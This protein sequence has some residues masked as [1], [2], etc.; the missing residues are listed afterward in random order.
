MKTVQLV[1]VGLAWLACSLANGYTIVSNDN[2]V[3]GVQPSKFQLTI[4]QDAATQESTGIWFDYDGSELTAE[5][6]SVDEGS[7]WYVVHAGDRFT[8]E[9]IA[10]GDFTPLVT[11][12][13][14]LQPSAVVGSEDFYLGVVTGTWNE[15]LNPR[16]V[17]GW[18]HLRPIEPLSTTLTMV[19]NVLS[20]DSPGIVVGTT[21]LAPE[22]SQAAMIIGVVASLSAFRGKLR[23]T[24]RLR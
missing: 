9:S 8:P 22:P 13:P 3:F 21:T 10:A 12:G 7:D 14:V 16:T 11:F 15:F 5:L 4:F 19:E 18:V 1:V 20:Y 2:M 23:L 17:F 24:R 6:S